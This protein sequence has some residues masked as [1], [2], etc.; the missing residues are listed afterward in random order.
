LGEF[1]L[2]GDPPPFDGVGES[3]APRRT[4]RTSSCWMSLPRPA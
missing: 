3:C 4:V 1:Q 2:T